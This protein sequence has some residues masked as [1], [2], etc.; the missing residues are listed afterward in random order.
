M[1]HRLQI[2]F[3]AAL[4]ALAAVTMHGAQFKFT[5]QTLTI[6][7]GFEVELVT[8]TNLVQRPV[9]G[10][11]DE[12]GRLYVTDSS[13]SNAKL[14]DQISNPDSRVVRLEDTDGDGKFDK[15]IVFAD[16]VVF[17]EGCL[18]Y[19][20]AVYISAVP[21]IWKL[22][23]TNNDGVADVRVEWHQ[24]KT[25]TGCGND[26]H[27]PFLGPDG[28]LYWCKGGS[29][30]QSYVVNGKPFTSRAAHIFRKR[31]DGTGIE[32][33]LTGGM[34]NPVGVTFTAEGERILCGTFFAPD[35][36][37]HRDGLIHAVYGGV[38]GK[39]NPS[40]EGHKRTG[41]L[42]P[43][44]TH[45][46]PAAPA[47]VIRYESR[48][49]GDEYQNNL[50]CAQ[51]NKN[52]VS[53][54]ILV[55]DGATFKTT[56][57]DFLV[58]DNP[59]F[60]PTDVIEDAD[61]SLLI[62]DTGAWYKL[63]CPTS[64]LAK[65][66]VLGAIYRV[67]RVGAK[68]ILDPRGLDLAWEKLEPDDVV[69][70]LDDERPAV[71]KRAIEAV[72]KIGTQP[73]TNVVR[74]GGSA[75]QR[76]PAEAISRQLGNLKPQGR[77][78]AVWALM[79]ANKTN[80]EPLLG[81]FLTDEDENVRLA[82]L[83]SASV[84]RDRM[85][86][87]SVLAPS[88]SRRI[89]RAFAEALG[90]CEHGGAVPMLFEISKSPMDRVLEHSV[91]YA[92]IETINP[93]HASLSPLKS[94][95]RFRSPDPEA[96]AR[97][98]ST[99]TPLQYRIELIALDQME[100]G[101]LIPAHVVPFLT[102]S[103]PDLRKAAVWVADNHPEWGDGLADFF[104]QR[105][106]TRYISD[107]ER[108]ESIRQLPKFANSEAIQKIIANS[109]TDSAT[110]LSTRKLLLQAMAQADLKTTPQGWPD[111]V[112]AALDEKDEA[113][114]RAAIA[115]A[116]TLGQV[117][118]N[119]PNFAEQLRRVA[120]DMACPDDLRLEALAAL[121][122]G[123]Q[124]VEPDL[125]SFLC[126]NID[127][128]KSVAMRSPAASILARAKLS[129]AELLQLADTL[130]TIGPL[131]VSQLLPAFERTT[132]ESVGLK[133]IAALKESKG[134]PGARP[135]V[136]KALAMKYPAA[137]Q[138]AADELLLSL[139]ADA[140]KQGAHIDE[141][142]ANLPKGEIRN[143]QAIFNS[144][145]AACSACHKIG[146]AG[147]TVGPDLTQIGEVRTE[148]DLLEAIVYPSASFVRSYE[149]FIVRTKSDADYSGVLR[150]DAVDEIVLATGP[151]TEARIA[152]ADITE[153]RP[154]TV[155][156]MPAGLDQ[157]LSKQELADLVTFLKNTK[158][159]PN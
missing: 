38:Y 111:A 33:V 90:R 113:L 128:S 108:A 61:G 68:R 88:A 39:V 142:L 158:W 65:P 15:S 100:N 145:K 31:P 148:R 141:L 71:F 44:M 49:F 79:R 81:R 69:K 144:P 8:T 143:G 105:I 37:G 136:L 63:C 82:A 57:S 98:M 84:R 40:I 117:K 64:Q 75:V 120:R 85:V 59:D 5:G 91:I 53:R 12:L 25:T 55:P 51:F 149:P 48:V 10:S 72:G 35:E 80:Y 14:V 34:D 147:G 150:R 29:A 30:E 83:H 87:R 93:D 74:F 97:R 123:L 121:P 2:L 127:P 21:S 67:R 41:D 86:V 66:D 104:Q 47:A 19:D 16:K 73:L 146:Y 52:K 43:V 99:W 94:V 119:A 18:Y 24:G 56:D 157:Q 46:G 139:N 129:D 92:L 155:S 130:K 114:V 137:V 118:M 109:L 70:L 62:V 115:T 45:M 23:D 156:V 152:R 78:N 101:G 77:R 125:L 3:A 13:G 134:L 135:D 140:K 50:F 58:S 133:L 11:F 112:R 32:P 110:S 106:T 132:D 20:G 103:D 153:M 60:H 122:R 126:A 89:K 28:W 36:P 26:L 76:G 42:M 96:A 9:S 27:G 95:S 22:T 116:R 107:S 138:R 4:S 17:P 6:P 151:N 124:S 154:G 54:H 159:G 1:H 102:W 7:D 131:E